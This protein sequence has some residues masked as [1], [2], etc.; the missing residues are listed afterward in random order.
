[1]NYLHYLNTW[2]LQPSTTKGHF[3]EKT[4]KQ[5]NSGIITLVRSISQGAAVC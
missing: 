2:N 3:F 4:D 5:T 1:M